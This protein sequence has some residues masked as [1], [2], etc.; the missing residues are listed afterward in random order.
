MSAHNRAFFVLV[1]VATLVA[2]IPGLATTPTSQAPSSPPLSSQAAP[3]SPEDVRPRVDYKGVSTCSSVACHGD[4]QHL[5]APWKSAYTVWATR[6]PHA[7]AYRVLW[8]PRSKRIAQLLAGE[9]SSDQVAPWQDARCLACHSLPGLAVEPN[10]KLPIAVSDGVSCEACHGSAERWLVAHTVQGWRSKSRQEKSRLGFYDLESLGSRVQHCAGCHVGDAGKGKVPRE[11]THDLIAAG[12]PRLAFEF[13]AY[14]ANMPR[15]WASEADEGS[16]GAANWAVGQVVTADAIA[17]LWTAHGEDY[18]E[19]SQYDC[20]ACHHDLQGQTWR[21]STVNLAGDD[22]KSLRPNSWYTSMLQPLQDLAGK[23]RK[24]PAAAAPLSVSDAREWALSQ[25]A[26]GLRAAMIRIATHGQTV[27]HWDDA[28]QTYHAL[29]ALNE[30]YR[31]KSGGTP[32]EQDQAISQAIRAIYQSL[33]FAGT[34]GDASAA[35]TLDSPETYR[36]A[37]F[38]QELEE[39]SKKLTGAGK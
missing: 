4:S 19:L 39:L 12:H 1:G 20:Y 29:A 14:Q 36:P 9:S 38:R 30:A 25:N 34:S 31:T 37:T 26:D 21:E 33:R 7:K 24:A 27:S 13:S 10:L 15:H 17:R 22:R 28:A 3:A 2:V 11:V 35:R 8:E 5:S 18:L 16:N 6:D 32:S 23:K